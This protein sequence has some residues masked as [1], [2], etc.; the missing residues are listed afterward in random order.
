MTQRTRDFHRVMTAE[1]VP[2]ETVITG[3]SG[4]IACTPFMQQHGRITSLGFLFGGQG[5][6]AYSSDVNDLPAEV[7]IVYMSPNENAKIKSDLVRV[8]WDIGV[9]SNGVDMI[10]LVLEYPDKTQGLMARAPTSN[11]NDFVELPLYETGNY[12]WHIRV[13][14]VGDTSFRYIGKWAKFTL[15]PPDNSDPQCPKRLG[16][17]TLTT[18]TGEH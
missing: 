8:E 15:S 17:V 13:Q 7:D 9:D 16:Y 6:L 18:H 14:M 4:D 11:G 2:T 1:D 3:P 10:L 5:E 12:Q